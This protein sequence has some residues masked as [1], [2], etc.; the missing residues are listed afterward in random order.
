VR[1]DSQL[2]GFVGGVTVASG[3]FSVWGQ[4]VAINTDA[5]LGPVT[6]FS[7][8]TSLADVQLADRVQVY[9]ALQNNADDAGHEIIR[10]TRIERLASSS[11]LPARLTGMLRA[12]STTGLR[13]AGLAL[14][15]SQTNNLANTAALQAGMWVTV[16]VPWPTDGSA[17]PMSWTALSVRTLTASATTD[18]SLRLSG[19]AQ[20]ATNGML[21]LQGVKV[22]ASAATLA[23]V[24]DKLAPGAYITVS[25]QFN[26]SSGK[27]VASS[28]ETTPASG[29]PMELR[30]SVT[31]VVSPTSFMVRGVQVNAALAQWTGGTPAELVSGR[32]VE[33]TGSL[34]NSVFT[35]GLVQ[36]QTT[37]PDKAVLDIT[38]VVQSINSASRIAQ[39]LTQD[40]Q[41]LSVAFAASAALPAVGDTLRIDGFWA[42]NLLQARDISSTAPL[43]RDLIHLEG[44]VDSV[45]SGQFRL[46]GVLVQVDAA[47]FPTLKISAGDR[48]DVQVR[49]NNEQHWLV[50]FETRPPRR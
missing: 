47:L 9:G 36:L 19:T 40:G 44:V 20:L 43:D 11:T 21:T 5:A 12:S 25:G 23:S 8:F 46:N 29:R 41:T 50:E 3:Q 38:A 27:L 10:A 6:V 24:R 1:L 14:D 34:V 45:S 48:V 13:L 30:G 22:D 42:D 7:G 39:V 16:V 35:A 49:R 18:T 2:V 28:I 33:V 37:L 17:T 4:T 31:S 26:H 32:Y 15:T